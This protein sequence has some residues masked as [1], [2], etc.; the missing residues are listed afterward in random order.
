MFFEYPLVVPAD[1]AKAAPATVDAV[2]CVGV[3][4]EVSI[5]FPAGCSG[6]VYVTIWRGG[7]P[8]WPVNIDE[9]VAGEDAIISFPES[10]ELDE[11]EYAFEVRGWSPG[12]TYS[13]TITVRFTVQ[14]LAEIAAEVI[15]RAVG[16]TLADIM[17]Y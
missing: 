13:H 1:T 3:V 15:A 16:L 17:G 4:T 7:H 11:Q 14:P 2:L 6:M 9:A 5:Q 12:T 10:Y 8:V